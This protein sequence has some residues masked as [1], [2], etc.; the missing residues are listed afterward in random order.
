MKDS[1]L[2]MPIAAAVPTD[3]ALSRDGSRLA[4]SQ[5][6]EQSGIWSVRIDPSGAPRG[7]PRP[8]V[9]NLSSRNTEPDFSLDGSMLAYASV[10]QG[11]R[12]AIFVANADGS[13]P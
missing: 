12:V 2:L 5:R 10:R 1:E 4:F 11:E 9:Q 8:L 3:I 7:E 13:A 6:I